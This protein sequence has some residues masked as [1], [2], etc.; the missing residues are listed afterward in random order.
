MSSLPV[1]HTPRLILKA[2]AETDTP[3]YEK[4][5]VDYEVIRQ[6][7][8]AVPWPYPEGGIIEFIKGTILPNQG[9][10]KWD[11]GI[12]LAANSSELIGGIGLRREGKPGHRGF[13]L[14]RAFWGRGYMTEAVE[15]IIDYAF[16]EL[17]FERLLFDNALGNIKS[18]RVKEKTGCRFLRVEPARFVDPAYRE[19]EFWELSREDWRAH[20]KLRHA[21]VDP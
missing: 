10:D 20:K 8:D 11:W 9:Q 5:F 16:T 19:R 2:I 12:F 4:H 17:G 6:L 21:A 1:F 7:A 18:R 3:A 13:W 14:G 15:P